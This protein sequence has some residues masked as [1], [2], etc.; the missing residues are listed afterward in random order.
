MEA[1]WVK[2]RILPIVAHID[3]YIA[4]LKTHRIPERLSQL[5]VFV[6][7]N[8]QFFLGRSTAAMACR[9]LEAGQIQLLGSDCH[10]QTVRKPNLGAA[11]KYIER[12]L[13]SDILFTICE[14]EHRIIN[15]E[16]LAY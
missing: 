2:R 3:R 14:Y 16:S 5:P 8:A 4:P 6:Q 15:R 1:I 9:M 7:A 12:K 10:D 13:G 11:V